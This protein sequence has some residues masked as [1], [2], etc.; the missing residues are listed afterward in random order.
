MRVIAEDFA[1]HLASGATS[2]CRCWRLTRMDGTV[3]G[4]TDHD[5][6]IDFDGTVF[7]PATGF[8]GSP[9]AAR[10]GGQVDTGEVLGILR[11]DTIS[12]VDIA[13][14]RY[15]G[16]IVETLKVNWQ[17]C[18]QRVLMRRDM[19]GEI[20]REDGVFRAEL[21]S[22]AQALNTRQGRVFHS[23]C[24]A[25]LG[26]R[27]CGVDLDNESLQAAATILTVEDAY[28]VAVSGLD[29]FEVGWFTFGAVR[30]AGG[31]LDGMSDVVTDHAVAA[32]IVTLAF[33]R[34]VGDWAFKGQALTVFAGCDRQHATCAKK[35]SNTVNFR[36]FPHIPG[37]DYLLRHPRNGDQLDGRPVVR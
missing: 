1:A 23:L 9:V 10:L 8:D 30:W 32:G 17:D 6:P 2:V 14:G 28:R 35:F 33:S 36:G 37:N 13:L 31:D 3:L 22:P 34:R 18:R 26:D 4:F 27:R 16:A 15:D 20:V 25:Q 5:C 24:D 11:S 29:A 21:R 12:E 7:S 19:I